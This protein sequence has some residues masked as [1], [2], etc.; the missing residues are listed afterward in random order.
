MH[1]L[2]CFCIPTSFAMLIIFFFFFLLQYFLL[3]ALLLSCP[4]DVFT[5]R[6]CL[7]SFFVSSF[8]EFPIPNNIAFI[9]EVGLGG[10]L[11]TVS[12]ML[13]CYWY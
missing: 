7:F 12:N 13:P 1:M 2:V 5:D 6:D 10:E 8:M 4:L 9:G 11:R 3:F